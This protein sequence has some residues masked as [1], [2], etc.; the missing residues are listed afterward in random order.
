MPK[1]LHIARLI[2]SSRAHGRDMLFGIAAYARAHG[3]WSFYC[4]E[5]LISTAAPAGL[6]NW[7]PDGI[8][9]GSTVAGC[10]SKSR[11]CGCPRWISAACTRSAAFRSSRPT[12]V[13]PPKWPPI[14]CWSAAC[15][16]S[17]IAGSPGCR[18][19]TIGARTSSDIWRSCGMGRASTSTRI[20]RGGPTHR[21]WKQSICCG[22]DRCCGGSN[23]CPSPSG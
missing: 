7:G 10:S 14:T 3:P 2:E 15:N 19:P 1:R 8:I 13:P 20:H 4:S 18:I 9:R 5:R 6:R 16:T 23:R 17:P 12:T 21:L 11:R 22:A